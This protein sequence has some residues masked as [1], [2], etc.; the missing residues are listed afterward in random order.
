[1][2]KIA[3]AGTKNNPSINFN[4]SEN[5]ISIEGRSV[6]QNMDDRFYG[7]LIQFLKEYSSQKKRGLV[8]EIFLDYFNTSSHPSLIQIF[9]ETAEI[10]DS[11]IHW[12]YEENDIEMMEIGHELQKYSSITFNIRQF[13]N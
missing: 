9:K 3:I 8:V 1:M 11:Q 7:A 5:K 4:E 10:E 12:L 13:I 2:M 6:L